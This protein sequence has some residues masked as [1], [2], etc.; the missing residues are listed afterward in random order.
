[1]EVKV[2]DIQ[3]AFTSAP[4]TEKLW[5]KC[6]PEFGSD[7]GK[8]AIIV[9]SLY[10][11]Y[12]AASAFRNHLAECMH[13]LGW[14]P[15]K[16]DNDLYYKP[17]T[18]P[19]DGFEYYAYCLLYIDDVLMISHDALPEIEHIGKYFTFKPDSIGDPEFY[20]GARLRPALLEN[21]VVA[22]GMSASKYVNA[23]VANVEKYLSTRNQSLPKRAA[24]PFPAGYEAELQGELARLS[25][26][27]FFCHPLSLNPN[28]RT[29]GH[30]LDWM[31]DC[32]VL[33]CD[34][35]CA[36]RAQRPTFFQVPVLH[37]KHY[38]YVLKFPVL[39]LCAVLHFHWLVCKT[40]LAF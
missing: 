10:G 24:T 25:R 19:E 14:E 2:G 33:Y 8:R 5:T 39:S 18:R 3:N 13:H 36:V 6:G 31:L 29:L 20:L 7:A 22:W 12:T 23:A 9:R 1:M 32:A 38:A 40:W 37:Y 4:A 28:G 34:Q 21:G 26:A 30:Q 11:T 35:A 27:I 17:M 15:C 16:A